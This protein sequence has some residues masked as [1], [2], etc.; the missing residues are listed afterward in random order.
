MPSG[1]SVFRRYTSALCSALVL[2]VFAVAAV[3]QQ[4]KQP[5]THETM[6]LMKRVGAPAVSPDGKWVVF[7]VAEPAYDD[8]DQSSDLWLV[9]ADGSAKPRKITFTKGGESGV[10]WSPDST[11]I[12]FSAKREGDEVSQI[13]VLN[14]SEP[15][16]AM[17]ITST[18]TGARGAQW[19]SDGKAILF[20]S[21]IF[22]GAMDDEANKKIATERKV[23]KYRVRTFDKFPIRYWDH[24][25]D[26]TQAHILVQQLDPNSKAV[27]ILAGTKLVAARGFAGRETASGEDLDAIWSPDSSSIIF[28]A[29]A[30]KDAAA[31][32]NV[33]THLYQIAASGGEPKQLT[34][35]K[36][37][38]INPKFRP[39][40]KALYAYCT[41]DNERVYNLTRL[42]MF[43]W[44]NPGEPAVITSAVDKSIG[45]F[46][47]TP[48]SKTIYFTA[49]DAGLEKLYSIPA[50]GGESKQVMDMPKG[51]VY[52]NVSIPEKAPSTV[53]IGTW[54]SA[55]NPTEIF[56]IDPA[57]KTNVPLTDFDTQEA[58]QIDWQPLRHFWFTAKNGK[59]IHNMVALPP[60]FDPNKKYPLLVLIHGGPYSM[61]RDQIT[62]R[63]N[64]HMLARPGYVVLMTDY[65]GSTG[66]GEEFAQ[67]IQGD[68]LK[69]PGDEV[70]EAADEAIRIFP[71][72]DGTRQAAAGASY[73]GHLANWLQASTA[74]YKCLISHAGL[75]N[76]ESQWGT[77]DGIYSREVTNGGPVWEQGKIWREQNPIRY[78]A[79]FKTP[80]LLSVGENDFRVPLNNTL[81]NWA[82]LQRLRVPSRLLVWPGENHWI[83]N[84]E[85]SRYFYKEVYDWLKKYIGTGPETSAP[86]AATNATGN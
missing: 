2:I 7:S 17:R 69:T 27:D 37:S 81:E 84:P 4:A 5:I 39:D 26:D 62:L 58:A 46:A 49:E 31:Y 18:S 55:V 28:A 53:L 86:V 11:R 65:T 82:I 56:R 70:N 78:A 24:W 50:N 19:R 59:K 57:N 29:T 68:P 36:V 6:W 83:L 51:G 41:P 64:Y 25:L 14:I 67:G 45:G 44:P 34:T 15:G 42:A 80:I 33:S 30:E 52:G 21:S 54:E 22:P 1:I 63:W 73:G 76:L 16:E 48:D 72:V 40:G 85:N 74:R 10:A 8:K 43:S 35:D 66:Y 47:F 13:Y 32:A 20:V 38:Y 79:N 61:W 71:F 3:A 12:A 23:Q 9:P 77:S 75:V 60:A